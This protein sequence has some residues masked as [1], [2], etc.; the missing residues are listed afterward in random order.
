[1]HAHLAAHAQAQAQAQLGDQGP[2]S[3]KKKAAGKKKQKASPEP[4]GA[5]RAPA[6]QNQNQG[7]PTALDNLL[8]GW[9]PV[10]SLPAPVPAPAPPSDPIGIR[11]WT[12]RVFYGNS[13][14]G[15]APAG[16]QA[17]AAQNGERSDTQSMLLLP[18]LPQQEARPA[19]LP[20][21]PSEPPAEP[22]AQ[23]S[24]FALQHPLM[25]DSG[26]LEDLLPEWNGT[27]QL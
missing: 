20:A 25:M 9:A 21:V 5:G 27:Y 10:V 4:E 1:V 15:G 19:A 22:P 6:N 12:Q 24:R 26:D 7:D 11:E 17:P 18:Q 16:E 2:A 13:P 23:Q 3:K 14:P 8:M